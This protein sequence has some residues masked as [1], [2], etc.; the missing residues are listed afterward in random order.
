MD[1]V[2]I[3]K[4]ISLIPLPLLPRGEGGIKLIIKAFLSPLPKGEGWVRDKNDA[5]KTAS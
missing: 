5:I 3:E 4:G 1:T 2:F